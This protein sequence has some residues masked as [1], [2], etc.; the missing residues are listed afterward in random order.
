MNNI[1]EIGNL[2][3]SYDSF[4]LVQH[5][6]PVLHVRDIQIPRDRITFVLGPTGSGKRTLMKALG[7]LSDN[8]CLEENYRSENVFYVDSH[9]KYF[10]LGD[11]ILENRWENRWEVDMVGSREYIWGYRYGEGTKPANFRSDYFSYVFHK[12]FLVKN[13]TILENA[14]LF[15]YNNDPGNA[16][17]NAHDLL[18]SYLGLSCGLNRLPNECRSET[19][20]KIALARAL[21]AKAEVLFVEDP[22]GKLSCQ[23]SYL[24]YE[25]IRNFLRKNISKNTNG[26]RSA[27]VFSQ[28]LH[29][30]LAFADRIIVLLPPD[31]HEDGEH[32]NREPPIC[33]TNPFFLYDNEKI[34]WRINNEVDSD[35]ND[36][37]KIR[38]EI[39]FLMNKRFISLSNLLVEITE[40]VMNQHPAEIDDLRL[41]SE[42]KKLFTE[43]F[44]DTVY[45]DYINQNNSDLFFE[46]IES[47]IKKIET[48]MVHLSSESFWREIVSILK[49]MKGENGY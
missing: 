2:Y 40:S 39:S 20:H 5:Q 44:S 1:F 31:Y 38:N 24:Y 28:N 15:N 14:S 49:R 45:S 48:E 13:L 41:F 23:D 35:N 12:P 16:E 3:C 29:L 25:S 34:Q 21:G 10:N 36:F 30:A 32:E 4:M 18:Y 46:E 7:L 11:L 19:Q 27:I 26:I 33:R 47:L 8:F 6:Y 22:T 42:L 43:S 37:K 17:H 9:G